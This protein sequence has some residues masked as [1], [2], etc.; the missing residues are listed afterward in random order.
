MRR[1]LGY[2][3]PYRT[4][5]A[6]SLLFLLVQ[7]AL[8]VLGPLLTRTAVD[9]YIA[10]NPGQVP[11]FLAHFLPADAWSGLTRIGVLYLAILATSLQFMMYGCNTWPAA[12]FDLP[13]DGASTES[14][15]RSTI[16][17]CPGLVTRVTTDV[18]VGTTFRQHLVD[19]GDVLVLIFIQ[20]S[21]SVSPVLTAIMLTA[22]PFVILTR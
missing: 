22:M 20:R 9:R 4:L 15:T 7:S 17:T 5:V 1:L 6:V 11:T 13:A 3:R 12:M 2:M 18:N 21:C 19:L 8:Q 10:P 16:A 14:D